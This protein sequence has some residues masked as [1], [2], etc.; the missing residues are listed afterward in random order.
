VPKQK[1]PGSPGRSEKEACVNWQYGARLI[2]QAFSY[3][4]L[5][6]VFDLWMSGSGSGLKTPPFASCV[7]IF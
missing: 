5:T 4:Y 7:E 6:W 3:L 1:A 2:S